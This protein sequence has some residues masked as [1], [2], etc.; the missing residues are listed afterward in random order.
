M[1]ILL[2]IHCTP[3][4]TAVDLCTPSDESTAVYIVYMKVVYYI[5]GYT[6]VY[7]MYTTVHR[8]IYT[9]VA[10]P[11]HCTII[12]EGKKFQKLNDF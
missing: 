12:P 10:N 4:Y 6:S 1:C 2:Y 9:H 8:P 7:S 3:M 5:H 11:G